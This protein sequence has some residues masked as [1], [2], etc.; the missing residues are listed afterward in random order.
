M[1]VKSI[2]GVIFVSEH[3]EKLASFYSRGL[4]IELEKEDHGGLDIHFGTDIGTVH[5]AIHPPSNFGDRGP[6]RGTAVAFQVDSIA[7][8]LDALQELGAQVV[9]EP[10]DEGF[11]MVVTLADPDGNL[12]ELV[13]LTH[14]FVAQSG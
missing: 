1:P 9:T 2:C 3:V 8:H 4:G 5:F 10:H 6:S 13:E 11:G 14:E 7:E 12:F